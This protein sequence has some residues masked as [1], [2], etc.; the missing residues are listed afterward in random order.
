MAA[1]GDPTSDRVIEFVTA[2]AAR[3]K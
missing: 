2:E 3:A 1:E